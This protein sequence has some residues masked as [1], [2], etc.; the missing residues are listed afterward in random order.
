MLA[1]ALRRP[2]RQTHVTSQVATRSAKGVIPEKDIE[3]AWREQFEFDSHA[4][5]ASRGEGNRPRAYRG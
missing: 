4:T 2:H 3:R 1:I 5:L